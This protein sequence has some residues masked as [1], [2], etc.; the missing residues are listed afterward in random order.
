M[1]K[2]G[3][4]STLLGPCQKYGCFRF[5]DRGPSGSG[6][7]REAPLGYLWAF[8]GPPGASRRPPGPKTNRSK[9]HRNP[10]ELIEQWSQRWVD[11]PDSRHTSK[12]SHEFCRPHAGPRNTARGP[13]RRGARPRRC[14]DAHK[15]QASWRQPHK[16]LWSK[17]RRGILCGV[18]S[19][20]GHEGV[21]FWP[22]FGQTWPR[23]PSRSTGL[24]SQ[25]RLHR[26]SA[27]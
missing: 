9:K 27:S 2:S 14:S 11:L 10:K 20:G 21:D 12:K 22:L 26:K 5:F 6:G 3:R 13:A 23:G 7:P 24:A 4:K 8:P 1:P 18:W 19:L 15:P 17:P 16:P 25:Y